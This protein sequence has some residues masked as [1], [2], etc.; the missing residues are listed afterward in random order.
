MN[1]SYLTL[2]HICVKQFETN[3]SIQRHFWKSLDLLLIFGVKILE[4]EMKS[5]NCIK[6]MIIITC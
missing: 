2:L 4:E 3:F 5:G 1:A 6:L